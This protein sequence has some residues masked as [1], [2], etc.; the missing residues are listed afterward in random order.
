M[1]PR[2][3]THAKH[4]TDA[5]N[6]KRNDQTNNTVEVLGKC[7]DNIQNTPMLW[8]ANAIF[9]VCWIFLTSICTGEEKPSY[10]NIYC[11]KWGLS[12]CNQRI[13]IQVSL[14][15]PPF[16]LNK[17]AIRGVKN[18]DFGNLDNSSLDLL[19]MTIQSLK[20]IIPSN[21]LLAAWVGDGIYIDISSN[22]LL[23]PHFK[24]KLSSATGC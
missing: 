3:S 18:T 6:K 15:F 16:L 12:N 1:Q 22:I 5:R 8:C 13:P 14:I 9:S 11:Q 10:S 24:N 23:S 21:R 20:R 2:V 17:M 19:D 4:A 7:V